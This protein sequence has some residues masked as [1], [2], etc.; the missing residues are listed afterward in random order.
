[1]EFAPAQMCVG[2]AT[3]QNPEKTLEQKKELPG[4]YR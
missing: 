1:M 2:E 3:G 4:L